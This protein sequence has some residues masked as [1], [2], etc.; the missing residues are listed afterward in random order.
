MGNRVDN[1]AID[2][3]MQHLLEAFQPKSNWNRIS[4]ALSLQQIPKPLLKTAKTRL[5]TLAGSETRQLLA[6]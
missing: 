5:A 4:A 6:C 1:T 2:Q 3:A